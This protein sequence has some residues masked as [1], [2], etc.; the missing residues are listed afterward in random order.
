MIHSDEI[1]IQLDIFRKKNLDVRA[2]T[3]GISLLDCHRADAV[4]S[5]CTAIKDKIQ[6]HAANL[7]ATAKRSA[8]N[9]PF[10]L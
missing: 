3:L 4:A 8:A 7:V 10:R 1:S 2:V 9:T 6:F 5:T